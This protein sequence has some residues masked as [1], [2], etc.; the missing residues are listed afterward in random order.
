[1]L[2]ISIRYEFK[3]CERDVVAKIKI[4]CINGCVNIGRKEFIL[5]LDTDKDKQ[6]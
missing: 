4:V 2:E 3:K 1:M 5:G 6:K